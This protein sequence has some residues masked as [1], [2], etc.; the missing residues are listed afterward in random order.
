M[1]FQPFVPTGGLAG[2][3]FLQ[4]TMEVQKTAH[5]KSAVIQR[6]LDYFRENIGKINTPEE[7]V[8]DYRLLSVALG[9]FGLDED[10]N[11]RHLIKTVLAEGV[12][13]PK[14][15]ANK[16]SDKRYRDLS[17]A[18]GFGD[19][20]SPSSKMPDFADK[21]EALY[22]DR[23]FETDMGATDETMRLALNAKREL[24]ELGA[25]PGSNRT[26]WFTLMS[27][28]PLRTV[29]ETALNLP[30]SFA[31]LS[32]DRQLEDFM[33]RAE[34]RFGTSDLSELGKGEALDKVVDRYTIMA[35]LS[36]ES[37]ASSPAL[38]LLRGY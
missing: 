7:L 29:M 19:F 12:D 18:F 17:R 11:S 23:R 6:D 34:A 28:P 31:A 5:G 15:L 33:E 10:I 9:A 38:M 21:I 24:A 8:K 27:T 25:G 3:R 36:T 13:D 26:K 20:A 2:W 35:G 22:K 1:T 4:T 32:I 30:S 37:S 14:S 16:M